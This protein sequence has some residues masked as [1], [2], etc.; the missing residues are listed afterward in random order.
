MRTFARGAVALALAVVVGGVSAGV[1][2][3]KAAYDRITMQHQEKQQW[4]W[5]S[6]GLTIAKFQ[7]F[8]STQ[9]DFCERASQHFN[10]VSC[11]NKPATLGDMAGAWADLGMKHP[12]KGLNRAASFAEIKSEVD[13]GRPVAARIGWKQGGGHMNVVFGYNEEEGTVA[14]ADPWPDTTTYTWWKYDDYV[15]NAHF[16]WTHSGIQ[17]SR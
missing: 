15:K 8:G 13:A 17:I 10:K 2:Q 4:C 1:A 6:A 9:T 14:V 7:G 5:V 11:D 12:G 3:A 16:A